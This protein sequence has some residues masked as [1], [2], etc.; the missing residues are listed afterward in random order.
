MQILGLDRRLT[1]ERE[2]AIYRI[3]QELVQNVFKHANA[4]S[5]RIQII[6]HRDTPNIIVEDN[7]RGMQKQNITRG[8]GFSTI[9]S[10]VSLLKGSFAIESQPGKGTMVLVD[11]PV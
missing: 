5:L 11:L 7:G 6:D 2:V 1:E 8:F 3:C 4:S 10:K 9:Q